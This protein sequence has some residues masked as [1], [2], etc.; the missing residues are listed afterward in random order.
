MRTKLLLI[1]AAF[2]A[3]GNVPVHAKTT[4]IANLIAKA[5]NE[6]QYLAFGDPDH[7]H[8]DVYKMVSHPMI[9]KTLAAQGYKSIAIESP[10]YMQKSITLYA[11]GKISRNAFIHGTD[12]F[13]DNA[14][15][16]D[17]QYLNMLADFIVAARLVGINIYAV[18]NAAGF[19]S[20]QNAAAFHDA[21]S[22]SAVSW[23]KTIQKKPNILKKSEKD[24]QAAMAMSILPHALSFKKVLQN[25]ERIKAQNKTDT[26]ERYRH[27]AD[28]ARRIKALSKNGKVAII[29]GNMHF[30]RNKGDRMG[31]DIDHHLGEDKVTTINIY[32]DLETYKS[33]N[34]GEL[35]R[36]MADPKS[37]PVYAEDK[38]LFDLL[39]SVADRPEYELDIKS[40]T[41][42]DW[43]HKKAT[44][45]SLP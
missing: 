16:D 25:E 29:F 38:P 19:V 27:D 23:A 12:P 37:Q 24:K 28:T 33:G 9:L 2:F 18:D 8:L 1:L 7:N 21:L 44:L 4:P 20:T 22:K 36:R 13:F 34:D 17:G 42:L 39:R 32:Y 3:F 11:T 26:T 6:G 31:G 5:A 43:T 35:W 15:V 41:W 40:A 10:L 45:V 14:Y 30:E